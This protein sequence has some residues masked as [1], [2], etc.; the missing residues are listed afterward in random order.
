MPSKTSRQLFDWI[1]YS[2]ATVSV[3]LN[4][5]HWRI[6][7]VFVRGEDVWVG[8]RHRSLRISWMMLSLTLWIDDGS[9]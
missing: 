8:S 9:W 4:P 6:L 1:V 3:T 2:G 5:F 7:P